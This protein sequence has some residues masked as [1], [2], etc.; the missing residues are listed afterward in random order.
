MSEKQN[1][2]LVPG[3]G[4]DQIVWQHQQ[5]HLADLAN[6]I[7]VNVNGCDTP[8]AIVSAIIEQAPYEFALA[9]HS[10][11]GWMCLELLKEYS[12]RVTKLCLLATG[13]DKDDHI[14]LERRQTRLAMT[15]AGEYEKVVNEILY[16]FTNNESLKPMISKMLLRNKKLFI[17]QNHA[18]LL[19]QSCREILSTL[20][21]PTMVI[22][23][24]DERL[25]FES[26]EII[27]HEIP[28]AKF[29]VIPDCSHM[30]TIEKPEEVTALMRQWLES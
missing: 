17:S 11:G 7:I 19:R 18:A 22:V 9:G 4:C 16:F 8:D 23:G 12:H 13:A 30:L 29:E 28:N 14:S 1:L 3:L 5:H 20:T 10:L 21:L 26:S 6:V 2:I 24:Q 25:F 27:A 15:Q